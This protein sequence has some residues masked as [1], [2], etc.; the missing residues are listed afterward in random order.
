MWFVPI[1]V[2]CLNCLK[3]GQLI[4]RKI[5]AARPV[6]ST[7]GGWSIPQSPHHWVLVQPCDRWGS[8][9]GGPCSLRISTICN[10]FLHGGRYTSATT[11]DCNKRIKKMHFNMQL[12]VACQQ[13]YK[14]CSTV[15]TLHATG[16]HNLMLKCTKF[17]F[18]WGSAPD[19]AGGAYSAPPDPLAGLKGS[20]F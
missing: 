2:Y 11:N 10:N 13:G 4:L 6:G 5:V 17:D 18:D 20:Y 19:P 12:W 16:C 8:H 1:C 14:G 7:P 3:F 9:G 15:A